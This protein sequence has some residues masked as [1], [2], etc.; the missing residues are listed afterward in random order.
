MRFKFSDIAFLFFI[1]LING[2]FLIISYGTNAWS[3][4]NY[5]VTKNKATVQES[6]TASALKLWK[7]I[8]TRIM[9]TQTLNIAVFYYYVINQNDYFFNF[10]RW[11]RRRSGISDVRFY[12]S[13]FILS[14]VFILITHFVCTNENNK[15]FQTQT[16]WIC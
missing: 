11:S 2:L 10:Y 6:G 8:G 12:F 4:F 9:I 13:F 5:R 15:L 3:T 7:L 16:Q 14:Y 1:L